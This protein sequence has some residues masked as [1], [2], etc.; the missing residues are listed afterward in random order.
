MTAATTTMDAHADDPRSRLVFDDADAEMIDADDACELPQGTPAR[1]GIG[2]GRVPRVLTTMD[3]A[4]LTA[5]GRK[6]TSSSVF[7]RLNASLGDFFRAGEKR[8]RVASP[9]VKSNRRKS[10]GGGRMGDVS[11]VVR[12]LASVLEEPKLQL[13][14]RAVDAIGEAR[15]REFV[16]EAL[17]VQDQGGEMTANGERKRTTGGVFWAH[18]R[19]QCTA[20]E[21]DVIFAEEREIQKQRAKIRRARAAAMGKENVPPVGVAAPQ[22]T[23]AQILFGSIRQEHFA[24]RSPLAT[25]SPVSMPNAVVDCD[26]VTPQPT[27]KTASW[28]DENDEND[29]PAAPMKS[30]ASPQTP[31]MSFAAAISRGLPR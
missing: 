30:R 9:A 10:V 28:A 3:E 18:V 20:Q 13:L 1:D 6:D 25:I 2:A 8:E 31:T 22:P 24:T 4:A 14:A 27:V 7:S 5:S 17:R 19:A 29:F 12:D 15:C 11:R 23:M 26:V 16:D 21:I